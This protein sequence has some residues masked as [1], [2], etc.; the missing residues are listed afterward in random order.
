MRLGGRRVQAGHAA[1][2]GRRARVHRRRRPV[3]R[4][5]QRQGRRLQRHR[6]QRRAAGWTVRH[7]QSASAS[8]GRSCARARSAACARARRAH[9]RDLQRQGRRLQ[10]RNRRQRAGHRRG[11][12]HRLGR[13]RAVQAGRRAL[14]RRQDH[15]AWAARHIHPP[16]CTCPPDDCSLP[17]D[18]GGA[19]AAARAARRASRCACRTPCARASS[20]ARA[21]SCAAT[22]SACRPSAAASCASRSRC[23]WNRHVRRISARR[24]PAR[25]DRSAS[26]GRVRRK[27]LLRQGCPAGQIC[28]MDGCQPDPCVGVSAQGDQFCRGGTVRAPP[29]PA[30]PARRLELPGRSCVADPCAAQV[31]RGR[32]RAPS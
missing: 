25:P 3:A 14:H 2:P 8:R 12:Q 6:R 9:A 10:R 15:T 27:H 1:V 17:G 21:R 23:A 7:R 20:P 22:A 26:Q 16:Q 18:G 29:A 4:D 24:R 5:L 13:Q 28:K 30:S 32:R 31:R 19:R 11:V